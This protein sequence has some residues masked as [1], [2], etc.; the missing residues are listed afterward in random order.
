MLLERDV[1]LRV[2]AAVLFEGQAEAVIPTLQT[3]AA[4]VAAEP[5]GEGG[6]DDPTARN[7]PAGERKDAQP[8][9]VAPT[10]PTNDPTAAKPNPPG[11]STPPAPMRPRSVDV[12]ERR[13]AARRKR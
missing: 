13:D 3:R 6:G 2:I 8:V 12:R 5:K 11:A 10:T 4:S 1:K 9:V 7:E